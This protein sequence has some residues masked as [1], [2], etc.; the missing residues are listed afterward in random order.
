MTTI[1]SQKQTMPI[2]TLP[3]AVNLSLRFGGASGSSSNCVPIAPRSGD[4]GY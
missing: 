3:T 4:F 2:A 1:T